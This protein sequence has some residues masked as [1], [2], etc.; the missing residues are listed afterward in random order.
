MSDLRGSLAPQKSS[1]LK[2]LNDSTDTI[3]LGGL[4]VCTFF[5]TMYYILLGIQVTTNTF[6][7]ISPFTKGPL[8]SK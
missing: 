5:L 3:Y 8:F 2:M 4:G 7:T 1:E 6:Y